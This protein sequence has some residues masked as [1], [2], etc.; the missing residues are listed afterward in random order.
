MDQR[1]HDR[2]LPRFRA[3][4][5]AINIEN[6]RQKKHHPRDG[7]HFP[8]RH[9]VPIFFN[10]WVGVK[11]EQKAE[12]CCIMSGP[13]PADM[14]SVLTLECVLGHG[15]LARDRAVAIDHI[16]QRDVGRLDNG[17]VDWLLPVSCSQG[18]GPGIWEPAVP[19]YSDRYP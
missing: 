17:E 15:D 9:H 6:A 12:E 10:P 5:L 13:M 4:R 14:G 7:R 16:D 8:K 1:F 2:P 19:T 11:A 18:N 3:E